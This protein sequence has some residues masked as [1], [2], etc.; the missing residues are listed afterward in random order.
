MCLERTSQIKWNK[1]IY[2]TH[3]KIYKNIYML[4]KCS[5]LEILA[6]NCDIKY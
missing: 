4:Q 3:I 1:N 5:T 2:K 6:I